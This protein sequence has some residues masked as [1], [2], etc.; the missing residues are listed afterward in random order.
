[1]INTDAFSTGQ[2]G[3]KLWVCR[4]LEKLKW[5]SHTTSIYG[6]WYGVLAF[7]LLSREKFKV[8]NIRSY[9]VDPA[10]ENIADMFNENWV[11]QEWK[12]KAFTADCNLLEWDT[13]VDLVINTSTEH[14]SSLDWWNNIPLGTRVIIQS[15]DMAHDDHVFNF[16]NED[17]F[18]EQFPLSTVA[19]KGT[20][21][22]VYPS[23]KFNRYMLIGIK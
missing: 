15:N 1:M 3:S 13:S 20:K 14:F 7:L 18:L 12:F 17:E 19:Y 16:N 8:N 4:E 11:F 22:F 9:D 5:N 23:W 10:C 2:I 6:G 21:K